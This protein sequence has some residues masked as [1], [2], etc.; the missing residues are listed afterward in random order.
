MNIM[1]YFWISAGI[2]IVL[3]VLS[4]LLF[5][6]LGSRKAEQKDRM[7]EELRNELNM[8]NSELY[9]ASSQ[10]SSVS[11][12]LHINMDENNAFAQQVYAEASEMADLNAGVNENVQ[13]MLDNV[14]NMVE[15][16]NDALSTSKLMESE[17]RSS[18]HTIKAS[19]DEILNIVETIHGIESTFG[20]T[21]DFI[22]KLSETAN[23][24]HSIL[25]TVN[26]ISKQTNLL[27]LNASIES[28]RAGE[29]GRG[30]SV[31]A[32]EIRKLAGESEKAVRDIAQ[33]VRAIQS[34][35]VGVNELIGENM[36][37]IEKGV[38]ESRNVEENLG[39]IR[40]S[41]SGVLE[42]A[43][44]V[45]KGSEGQVRHANFVIENM[46]SVDG[47]VRALAKSVDDVKASVYKQKEGIQEIA[48]MS[49]R[50]NSASG[51]L[52]GLLNR[53]GIG[54][55]KHEAAHSSEKIEEAFKLIR[56]LAGKPDFIQMEKTLHR[57]ALENLLSSYGYIEAAWSNDAKGRFIC[58]IPEAGI[59]NATIR[60][61]FVR[62]ISGEEY[63]SGVYISAITR[64]PCVTL[65]M[66][67]KSEKGSILGVV[68]IDLKI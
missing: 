63:T 51:N 18:G 26:N 10:I 34:E 67:I 44:R 36:L 64:K 50:L 38:V 58:S 48:E 2:F 4:G 14:K 1:L 49:G 7:I 53:S 42:M 22:K 47:I 12:Q 25:E 40:K 16:L 8:H 24:I 28:A 39:S 27:S 35:V 61:W 66:P 59:A 32:D 9:V 31:V 52:T 57:E 13:S 45:I 55:T 20:R 43:G 3:L 11:E 60:E 5:Y 65:S 19:L 41:F 23:R 29:N 62:G 30:F 68:G 33:L 46:E 37:M 21:V 54:D 15:L 6:R 17:S 56:E